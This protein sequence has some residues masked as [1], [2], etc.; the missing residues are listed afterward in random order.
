M[1]H[2]CATN[3]IMRMLCLYMFIAGYWY[4]QCTV[5]TRPVLTEHT[6]SLG[7]QQPREEC[8]EP[9]DNRPLYAGLQRVSQTVASHEVAGIGSVVQEFGFYSKCSGN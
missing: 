2:R 8:S 5:M 3:N 6:V 9:I 7:R 1:C 4:S